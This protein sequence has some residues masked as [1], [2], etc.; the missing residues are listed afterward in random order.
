MQVFS[1]ESSVVGF[2]MYITVLLVII[3]VT[4]HWHTFAN[5]LWYQLPNILS[6]TNN[7]NGNHKLKYTIATM[8]TLLLNWISIY[9]YIYNTA[10]CFRVS[11]WMVFFF[12]IHGSRVEPRQIDSFDWMLLVEMVNNMASKNAP[13]R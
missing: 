7:N 2:Q 4:L 10:R 12:Y 3:Q 1:I 11:H 6:G 13:L 8:H 9:I 5:E